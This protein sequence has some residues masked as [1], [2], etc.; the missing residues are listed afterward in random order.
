MYRHRTPAR[1]SEAVAGAVHEQG[2]IDH[3]SDVAAG[4]LADL[5]IE[6]RHLVIGRHDEPV[7][8]E[9]DDERPL[10]GRRACRLRKAQCRDQ[11]EKQSDDRRLEAGRMCGGSYRSPTL[12]EG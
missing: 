9:L 5:A 6:I 2:V 1:S 4:Q 8:H 12:A 11:E 7:V 10:F 3:A